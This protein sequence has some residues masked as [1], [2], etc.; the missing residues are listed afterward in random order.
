[1]TVLSTEKYRTYHGYKD[2]VSDSEQHCIDYIAVDSAHA[3]G[4]EV[5]ERHVTKDVVSSDHNPVFTRIKYEH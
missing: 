4:I 3:A 5:K 1:M 2:Y